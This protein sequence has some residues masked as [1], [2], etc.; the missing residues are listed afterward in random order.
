MSIATGQPVSAPVRLAP[1][2][3]RLSRTAINQA[4]GHYLRGCANVAMARTPLQAIMALQKTQT[5]LLRHSV[6]V[7]A[8]ATR[9]WRKQN[10]DL[11]AMGA[12]HSRTP[13]QSAAKVRMTRFQ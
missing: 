9:L 13:K 7:F 12:K 3:Q 10:T 5:G 11:L 6:H 2:W 8:E 4:M 1:E